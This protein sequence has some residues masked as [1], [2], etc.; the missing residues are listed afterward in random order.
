LKPKQT[1]AENQSNAL[2]EEKTLIEEATQKDENQSNA[3][4]E[5]KTL[6][7]EGSYTEG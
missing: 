7:E 6:I 1:I 3:L 5:E 2:V 4:V